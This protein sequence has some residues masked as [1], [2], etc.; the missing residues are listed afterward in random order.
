M[1]DPAPATAAEIAKGY[2]NI[3]GKEDFEFVEIQ[4]TGATTLPLQG[5]AFT[6][7]VNYTFPNVSL[8]GGQY[9]VVASDP[10][11]FAIRY[12]SSILSGEYG[13]NWLPEAGY[14]GHFNNAGEDVTLSSP[15]GGVIQDF[16]YDPG[17]FPQT[18]RRRILPHHPQF[19]PGPLVMEFQ[20]R[21]G[22]QRDARRHA[23]HG[24]NHADPPARFD[25]HQ[26]S[27]GQPCRHLAA[28]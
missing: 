19:Q 26:R 25:R 3:D 13:A 5:L 1:Y 12:G 4:N 22:T 9:I 14:T 7:G 16:S 15:G 24:G 11:A 23:R 20:C 18:A 21:L 2:T 27:P 17:L 8:A 10:A 6:N 28:T